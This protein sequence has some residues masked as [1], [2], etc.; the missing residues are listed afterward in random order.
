MTT[1]IYT[2]F[3]VRHNNACALMKSLK[4]ITVRVYKTCHKI[5]FGSL[6][7]LDIFTKYT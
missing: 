6:A 1:K 5:N 4:K 2:G 3:K 7:R